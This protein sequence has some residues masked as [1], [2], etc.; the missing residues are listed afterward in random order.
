MADFKLW[1]RASLE[2][3]A[4]EMLNA[5]LSALGWI[6]RDEET[7]G[8]NFGVG[9]SIR[10]ALK[11][12]SKFNFDENAKQRK[13]GGVMQWR[14]DGSGEWEAFSA[15]GDPACPPVWRIQVCDDGTFDVMQSDEGLIHGR[16]KTWKSLQ[17]A[18]E[19][20]E[21]GEMARVAKQGEGV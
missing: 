14:F 21:A 13:N 9:N 7:H 16:F 1:D 12:A 11:T 3:V 4:E 20:C 2:S 6:E 5:L 15:V 10:A 18:K 8:R 17:T 19:C